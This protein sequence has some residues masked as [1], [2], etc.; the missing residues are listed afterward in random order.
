MDIVTSL[1]HDDILFPCIFSRL[2]VE[3]LFK[4]RQVSTFFRDV[5]EQ[6]FT[7]CTDLDLSK[8]SK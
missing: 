6:Y 8:V 2:S 1:P 4:L 7:R 5:V 3:E